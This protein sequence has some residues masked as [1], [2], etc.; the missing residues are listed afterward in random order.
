[1]GG[2]RYPSHMEVGGLY[3]AQQRGL[4]HWEKGAGWEV[5]ILVGTT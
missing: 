4:R 5:G 3:G 1:M 2:G